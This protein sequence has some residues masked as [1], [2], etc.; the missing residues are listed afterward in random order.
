[1]R[2]APPSSAR[3]GRVKHFSIRT[4]HCYVCGAGRYLRFLKGTGALLF[5]CRDV[6]RIEITSCMPAPRL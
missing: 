1:M 2:H 3:D 6:L 5:L 4:E